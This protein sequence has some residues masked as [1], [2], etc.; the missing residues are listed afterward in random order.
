MLQ[1]TVLDG[2][3]GTPLLDRP[4]VDT[5]G[6]QMG[7]LSI[8]VEGLGNDMVLYWTANCLYHEGPTKPFSFIPGFYSMYY[9][10]HTLLPRQMS[11]AV[12]IIWLYFYT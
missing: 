7:G 12:D 1:T 3:T 4:V 6:S 11:Y 8:S 10:H 2:K 9:L 5:A